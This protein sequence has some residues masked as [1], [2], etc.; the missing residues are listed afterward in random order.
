MALTTSTGTNG[1]VLATNGLGVLSFIDASETK[2]LSLTYHKR[3]VHFSICFV[4][5]Q[6]QFQ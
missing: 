5:V 2:P 6:Q 4:Q 1:Q 3:L